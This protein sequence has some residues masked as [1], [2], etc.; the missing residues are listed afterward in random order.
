ML[1][2]AGKF[3]LSAAFLAMAVSCTG[4]EAGTD[5]AM[6]GTQPPPSTNP[7]DSPTAPDNVEGVGD[8][9]EIQGKLL[10]GTCAISTATPPIMTVAILDN[11]TAYFTKRASDGKIVLNANQVGGAPCEMVA[12][13]NIKVTASGTTASSIG[14]SVILD[15]ANG[16]FGGAVSA[17]VAGT[18]ID[19]S[20]AADA[21][22]KNTLKIRGTSGVDKYTFGPGATAG[23]YALNFDAPSV[24]TPPVDWVD[25][26]FKQVKTAIVNMG[27]GNDVISGAGGAGTG[28]TAF[29][30]VLKMYGGAGDDSLTGGLGDDFLVGGAGS[31]ALLA[32]AGTDTADY[33]ARTVDQTLKTIVGT[34]AAV[35]AN[36]T[37]YSG[38]LTAMTGLDLPG[39]RIADGIAIIKGGAGIDTITI[40]PTSTVAHTVFGGAGD[41]VFTGS[42]SGSG[43]DRFDGETGNDTCN[44]AY[45]AMSYATRTAPITVTIGA[46]VTDDGDPAIVTNVGAAAGA[47]ADE[48]TTGNGIIVLTGL[49]GM[50]VGDV[51]K[52]VVLSG[53]TVPAQDSGAAGCVITTYTSATSVRVDC[54]ANAMFDDTVSLAGTLTWSVIDPELDDVLCGNVYGGTGNDTITG[55]SGNNIIYGGAGNDAISGGAGSDQLFGEAGTDTIHGGA[56]DDTLNGGA[57]ADTLVGGDDDDFL[58]GGAGNDTFT[59][60]GANASGGG[61]GTSPGEV[62]T[63]VDFSSPGAG[64]D[65]AGAADCEF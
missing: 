32:S 14:R 54:T 13:G 3:R 31:D 60:D 20:G 30:G 6:N 15:Y 40:A 28:S 56:G 10:M 43:A 45:A 35:T 18:I 27:G 34:N 16:A 57:D 64:T 17:T 50:V 63:R 42:T 58:D 49:T 48:G 53:F 38:D 23:V 5:P 1:V 47:A 9:Q 7:A 24:A 8:F 61:A 52:F 12:T 41:D 65:I 29:P 37:D 21:T 19:L 39:D 11:E 26:T 2:Q 4:P 51:G 59:C 44:G 36:A 25:V 22:F 33:S 62:D 46:G 55:S